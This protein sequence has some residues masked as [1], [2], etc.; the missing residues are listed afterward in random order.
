MADTDYDVPEDYTSIQ[1]WLND[2]DGVTGTHTLNVG[3][4]YVDGQGLLNN[5]STAATAFVIKPK[6]GA[7]HNGTSRN[8]AS[9]G[10]ALRHT[11]IVLYWFST[12]G[13]TLSV[14]DMVLERTAGSTFTVDNT[15]SAGNDVS[16]VRCVVESRGTSTGTNIRLKDHVLTVHDSI[17]YG[18]TVYGI[19][20]RTAT[21]QSL[22]G[23]TVGDNATG[24][25]GLLPN[26]SGTAGPVANNISFGH[27]T[28]DY[29]NASPSNTNHKS[30]VAKDATAVNEWDG[31][32]GGVNNVE[33]HV[34]GDT[35]TGNYVAFVSLTAGSEDL[36][37]V[38]LGHGTYVNVALAGGAPS[39]G[40]GTDIDGDTRDGTTPDIGA[41]EM[42]AGGVVTV[43]N[44]F[45]NQSVQHASNF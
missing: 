36:H 21:D 6:A 32:N 22:I 43:N 41:D 37:L 1:T 42:A 29:F 27:S 11:D 20:I 14:E 39:L 12:N 34:T 2:Q 25:Y 3:D 31:G 40:S 10:A 5:A 8:V 45:V 38:D 26:N 44:L 28:E 13:A 9:A 16:L 17:I 24:Q 18:H 15:S 33:I 7:K 4:Q 35:P 19:D 30:N 23:N